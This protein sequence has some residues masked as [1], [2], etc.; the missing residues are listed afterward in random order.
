MVLRIEDILRKDFDP[1]SR[2]DDEIRFE[3][4]RI[5]IFKRIIYFALI[6]CTLGFVWLLAR[7]IPKLFILLNCSRTSLSKATR[8]CEKVSN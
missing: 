3:G 6:L 2:V 1:Q 7:W 8:I 4:F 5:N